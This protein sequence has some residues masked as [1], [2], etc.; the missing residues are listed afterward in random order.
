M[1]LTIL[2]IHICHVIN[3]KQHLT[4]TA[5][6]LTLISLSAECAQSKYIIVFIYL[7]IICGYK[8]LM[9]DFVYLQLNTLSCSL[10]V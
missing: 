5:L 10:G 6:A 1:I 2:Y 7:S 3:A 4:L 8:I 9:L